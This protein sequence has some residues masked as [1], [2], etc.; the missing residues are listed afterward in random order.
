M[1]CISK[2][3]VS[4]AGLAAPPR[5]WSR[6]GGGSDVLEQAQGT[7]RQRHTEIECVCW[8][9][10]EVGVKTHT[11]KIETEIEAGAKTHRQGVRGQRQRDTHRVRGRQ[12]DLLYPVERQ[13]LNKN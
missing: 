11:E 3:H 8:G 5:N 2:A 4:A 9:E 6:S 1:C 7:R 12:G 13:T 10:T